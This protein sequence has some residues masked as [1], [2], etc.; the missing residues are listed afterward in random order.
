[1]S[2]EDSLYSCFRGCFWVI[3]GGFSVYRGRFWDL[4]GW[5][6]LGGF[7]RVFWC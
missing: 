5:F 4:V 7:L 2:F 6:W 3:I 1:M